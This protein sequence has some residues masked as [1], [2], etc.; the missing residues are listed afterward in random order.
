MVIQHVWTKLHKII[1]MKLHA[2]I[3]THRDFNLFTVKS[4]GSRAMLT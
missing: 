3:I 2:D 4:Q 1:L